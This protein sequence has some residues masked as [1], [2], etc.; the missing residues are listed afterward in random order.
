MKNGLEAGDGPIQGGSGRWPGSVR[1]GRL[2]PSPRGSAVLPHAQAFLDH[3][4]ERAPAADV[5]RLLQAHE[6]IVKYPRQTRW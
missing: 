2:R 1:S 5:R 3:E 6:L 4:D